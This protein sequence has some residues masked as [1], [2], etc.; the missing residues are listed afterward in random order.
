M[1][2]KKQ[3][4]SS[5]VN[6]TW[7]V[8][9]SGYSWVWAAVRDNPIPVALRDDD[10]EQ[11][12]PKTL[13][14]VLIPNSPANGRPYEPLKEY[15]GLHRTLSAVKPSEAEIADF[16]ARFGPLTRTHI[17]T[18]RFTDLKGL[19]SRPGDSLS[20]WQVEIENLRNLIS[21]WETHRRKPTREVTEEF[22]KVLNLRLED[23][24]LVVGPDLDV[25]LEPR[26][27]RSAIWFQF[28]REI[29]GQVDLLRCVECHEWFK[30]NRQSIKTERRFCSQACRS[31]AYRRR[32]EKARSLHRRGVPIS[33]IAKRLR[34]KLPI[35]TD[36]IT[37]GDGST[38]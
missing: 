10:A 21:L 12:P 29:R 3:A 22:R 27:L 2:S 11:Q 18:T 19:E 5:V 14:R 8:H 23:I 37:R 7:E 20:E 6:L 9:P 34:S 4:G 30:Y 13:R 25:E 35:V 32:Q 38:D 16:A 33:Q 36:W 17:D 31:K 24:R 28:W 15:P 1:R 26:S